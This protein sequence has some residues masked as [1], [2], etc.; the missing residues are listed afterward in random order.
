MSKKA[1]LIRLDRIGDLCLTLPC[2]DRLRANGFD[3]IK[4][5]YPSGLDFVM[6]ASEPPRHGLAV[7]TNQGAGSSSIHSSGFSWQEF[8]T[9]FLYLRKHKFDMSITFHA[10]WWINLLLWLARVPARAGVKSQWH[11]YLFLNRGLRQKRSQAEKNELD[12]NLALTDFALELKKDSA[13]KRP[14]LQLQA[15]APSLKTVEKLGLIPKKYIIIH[16]GMGGSARNWSSE[17]YIALAR[18][19]SQKTT[20]VFTGTK[21]DREF[22]TPVQAALAGET[23]S[24]RYHWLNEK[25]SGPDLLSILACAKAV[26]APST[27]VV[28][29]AAALGVHTIGIYSPVLVQ[30]AT[31]WGPVGEKTETLTPNVDCPATHKCLEQA[32]PLF[33]CMNDIKPNQ[34]VERLN[35]P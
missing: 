13:E 26:I 19:L 34:I 17:N 12:Y 29:L 30:R 7:A 4:W 2:E 22:L 16:V 5:F 1:L 9:L 35:L 23:N 21:T 24:D 33:D 28:H 32:C 3:D 6:Q 27:G 18:E 25:L 15:P 11:S 8:L 14:S 20:V 10:P 31:R